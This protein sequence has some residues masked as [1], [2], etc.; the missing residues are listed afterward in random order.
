MDHTYIEYLGD[1]CYHDV[2]D[3]YTNVLIK[4]HYKIDNNEYNSVN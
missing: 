1:I 3:L 4:V 2:S